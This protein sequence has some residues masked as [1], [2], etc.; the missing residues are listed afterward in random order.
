M[1]RA[2]E[3]GASVWLAEQVELRPADSRRQRRW[4]G[5]QTLMQVTGTSARVRPLRQMEAASISTW[6]ALETSGSWYF[7]AVSK[8]T[9]LLQLP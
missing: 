8:Q 3:E 7:R 5:S 1:R 9:A 6:V 4:R 2:E